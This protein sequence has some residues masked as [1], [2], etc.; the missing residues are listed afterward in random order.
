MLE[1]QKTFSIED[2]ILP[3][4]RAQCEKGQ[5]RGPGPT[6]GSDHAE[7]LAESLFSQEDAK[8][9]RVRIVGQELGFL[10][11]F[12]WDGYPQDNFSGSKERRTFI[13][14]LNLETQEH[15]LLYTHSEVTEIVG[16]SVNHECTLLGFTT[17]VQYHNSD[18]NENAFE[19]VYESYL[20]EVQSQRPMLFNFN[21][22]RHH[23]Q[24]VQFLYSESRTL[25]HLLL[26]RH[27]ESIDVY[28]IHTGQG[29]HGIEIV[30]PAPHSEEIARRFIW[31]QFDLSRQCIYFL[32]LRPS[33]HCAL[34]YDTMLKCV[35]FTSKNRYEVKMDVALPLETLW[36][37]FADFKTEYCNV[38]CSHSLTFSPF[39]M[40]VV[41]MNGAGLCVCFQH[42]PH[43]ATKTNGTRGATGTPTQDDVTTTSSISYSVFVLHHSCT[44]V[45]SI[46]LPESVPTSALPGIR[47]HFASLNEL[48]LV[49]I[50]GMVMQLV[51]C[52]SKHEPGHHFVLLGDVVPTLPGHPREPSGGSP[53]AVSYFE[54]VRQTDGRN[55]YGVAIFDVRDGVAYTFEM[56]R[57]AIFDI[58]SKESETL[59]RRTLAL[60]LAI[61]HLSDPALTRRILEYFFA[62]SPDKLHLEIL[63]EYLIG[64]AYM[65]MQQHSMERD[66]LRLL[67]MTSIPTYYQE[68][69]GGAAGNN[70][71]QEC[72]IHYWYSKLDS[73]A[74]LEGTLGKVVQGEPYDCL[75]IQRTEQEVTRFS[76]DILHDKL[77]QHRERYQLD[78]EREKNRSPNLSVS[79]RES[80][81]PPKAK[82]DAFDMKRGS[83]FFGKRRSFFG[84]SPKKPPS[85]V[86]R[87]ASGSSKT[88]AANEQRSNSRTAFYDGPARGLSAPQDEEARLLQQRTLH[89]L[90]QHLRRFCPNSSS[91]QC[92]D[93]ANDYHNCQFLQSTEVFRLMMNVRTSAATVIATA[94]S[95]QNHDVGS[96][97]RLTKSSLKAAFEGVVDAPAKPYHRVSP[98]PSSVGSDDSVLHDEIQ[99]E[100]VL[101]R[102][103]EKTYSV[104]QEISFPFPQGFHHRF[105]TLAYR[106]LP[107]PLFKQYLATRVL[108]VTEEFVMRTLEE[109]ASKETKQENRFKFFL[110]SQLDGDALARAFKKWPHPECRRFLAD[111]TVMSI[112]ADASQEN[113][114][115]TDEEEDE[116]TMN[117]S[118]TM[119]FPPL[120]SFMRTLGKKEAAAN[121]V[122]RSANVSARV[123]LAFIE[124]SAMLD[125]VDDKQ[126]DKL[127]VSF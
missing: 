83:S 52:G 121:C 13:E 54:L 55:A 80:S 105:V 61:V 79:P 40:E 53:P 17:L 57:N 120:R 41:H 59:A 78:A 89:Y 42:A 92:L 63:T 28:A 60:H 16:A 109:L 15:K 44:L 9:A 81:Q 70:F 18:Q 85:P 94:A 106:T 112:L 73:Q 119:S 4:I 96:G 64:N 11:L 50:P 118:S 69:H 125:S 93:W 2:Q 71:E 10:L 26:F 34:G 117:P 27:K 5:I 25:S 108:R 7:L 6:D 82:P 49:Y 14:M 103:M 38:P 65:S 90:H 12:A 75:H 24:R 31:F 86:Q 72:P 66:F 91:E 100:K 127:D 22:P 8:K 95:V 62:V 35:Q 43:T 87:Q 36:A 101:F 123:S 99:N 88:T 1:F 68:L 104:L 30:D 45:Y 110:V 19:N 3:A 84:L 29:Q 56:N 39:N 67:P 48:L 46:P 126:Q 37:G 114:Q 58:F 107:R 21:T 77:A 113:V 97:M 116:P 102:L 51:D 74:L 47:L 32:Y 76:F 115:D 23:Y 98:V 33:Q 20:V 124:D 111:T 122:P